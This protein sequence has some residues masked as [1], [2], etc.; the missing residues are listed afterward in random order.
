[1]GCGVMKITKANQDDLSV[2]LELQYIAY[3]KEAIRYNDFSIPPLKQTLKHLL[4]E[5]ENSTILKATKDGN[6]IGSVRGIEQ[7]E[8]CKI[9]RLIVHPEF[10][11]QG[12]GYQLLACIEQYFSKVITFELFTGSDSEDNIKFYMES[13]YVEYKREQLTEK[14]DLV[15]FHK[16]NKNI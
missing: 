6:I 8:I 13:G 1:M 3:E 15:Y 16:P 2:I 11:R 14:I 10:Q 4:R 12:I 5:S 7:G 9:G